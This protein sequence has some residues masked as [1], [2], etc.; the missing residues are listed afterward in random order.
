MDW[1]VVF[2]AAGFGVSLVCAIGGLVWL[3][4]RLALEPLK[5]DISEL[6]AAVRPIEAKV[7][8]EPELQRIIDLAV[9]R[10]AEDCRLRHVGEPLRPSQSD[11]LPR[12]MTTGG[13]VVALVIAGLLGWLSCGCAYYKVDRET[14]EGRS[15]GFL[16]NLAA[17]RE[18]VLE[19][20]PDGTRVET[21]RETT[22]T[23][24]TT[25]DVLLG[26]NELLGT[27]VDAAEKAKP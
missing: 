14:G 6:K 22:T 15:Y 21:V 16:R 19:V 8:S 24:S 9:A 3:L 20:R 10:H 1:S 25:G 2:A 4:L 18:T 12:G 11:T 7:K 27:A 23:S 13:V 26:M 17:T 5:E